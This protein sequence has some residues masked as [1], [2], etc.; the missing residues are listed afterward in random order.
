MPVGW[1][2][3]ISSKYCIGRDIELLTLGAQGTSGSCCGMALGTAYPTRPAILLRCVGLTRPDPRDFES[4]LTRPDLTRSDLTRP[5]RVENLLTR[6]GRTR[7]ILNTPGDPTRGSGCDPQTFLVSTTRCDGCHASLL[8][9]G[10]RAAWLCRPYN[11]AK[12]KIERKAQKNKV[13]NKKEIEGMP[14]FEVRPSDLLS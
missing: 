11:E 2:E 8:S 6:P 7:E 9:T 5:A 10:P 3:R 12:L 1:P 4:L 14:G 13:R